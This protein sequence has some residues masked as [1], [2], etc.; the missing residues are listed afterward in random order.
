M[1]ETIQFPYLILA[2]QT[3]TQLRSSHG[4]QPVRISNPEPLLMVSIRAGNSILLKI[5]ETTTI[6]EKMV[7][8]DIQEDPMGME[9]VGEDM[10]EEGVVEM[11][12]VETLTI[13]TTDHGPVETHIPMTTKKT[14]SHQLD[15]IK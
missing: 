2:A 7:I 15:Q 12:E 14:L 10:A 8:I 4:V 6:L 5:M 11:G 9:V 1:K 3:P 13:T